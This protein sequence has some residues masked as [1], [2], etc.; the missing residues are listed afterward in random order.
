MAI[1]KNEPKQD[2]TPWVVRNSHG[3]IVHE[4][5]PPKKE[6][7]AKRDIMSYGEAAP[8]AR[9]YT[10]ETGIYAAPVRR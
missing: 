4:K 8:L 9:K 3:K 2:S 5:L 6:G 7:E 10:R 1:S